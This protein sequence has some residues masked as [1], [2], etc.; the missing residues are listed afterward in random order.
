M[1]QHYT[2]HVHKHGDIGIDMFKLEIEIATGNS[3]YR[4]LE[5]NHTFSPNKS[6]LNRTH[7]HYQQ[8]HLADSESASERMYI[9]LKYP[10]LHTTR[11]IHTQMLQ[12][13][14][15]TSLPIHTH[16]HTHSLN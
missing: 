9:K 10:T 12:H 5:V 15:A 14:Q 8:S 2:R 1:L 16:T 4:E 11:C 7:T 3:L 6:Y 13:K